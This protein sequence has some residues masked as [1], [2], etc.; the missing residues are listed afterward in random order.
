MRSVPGGARRRAARGFTL[1]EVLVAM[2]IL[3]VGVSALVMSAASA[4]RR[5]DYLRT[6]EYAR[7]IASN[8]MAEWQAVIGWPEV[9]TTNTETEM[10]NRTW[11]VRTRTQ[12]VADDDLRRLDIE[13]RGGPDEEGY[14][15][16][17]TGF[18][19]NPETRR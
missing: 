13:V 14:L 18:V 9:G 11:Y 3:A 4:T 17:V 15:Y 19:G 10:L 8:T 5:A 2:T 16:S 1:V 7:W 12:R 6:R